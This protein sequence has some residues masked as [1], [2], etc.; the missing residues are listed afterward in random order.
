[1]LVALGWLA[2]AWTGGDD[3]PKTPT[4]PI[5][6]LVDVL[7]EK[8]AAKPCT[9]EK[10]RAND[11]A[12]ADAP[13]TA[14]TPTGPT[15]SS[16][17]WPLTLAEVMRIGLGNNE[18]FRNAQTPLA[19]RKAGVSS[20]RL[21]AEVMALVRSIEQCYWTLSQ[22]YVELWASEKAVE[23]AREVLK[24]EQAE[25]DIGGRGNKSDVA[26]AEQRLEQ[27]NLDM[28][29]RTSDVIEAERRL[30]NVL[31]L[32]RSDGRRITPMTKPRSDQVEPCW[33]E[34][35]ATM[36]LRQPDL[37]EQSERVRQADWLAKSASRVLAASLPGAELDPELARQIEGRWSSEAAR[38]A[39]LLKQVKHQTTHS[40]ARFFLEVDANYKQFKTASRLCAAS[41]QRLEA[42]RAFYEEG[43]IPIDRYLDAISQYASAKTQEA[44]FQATYNI[45]LVAL[46]EAK[47][48]LLNARDIEICEESSS[49]HDQTRDAAVETTAFTAAAPSDKTGDCC[50]RANTAAAP[51]DKAGDCCTRCKPEASPTANEPKAAPAPAAAAGKTL[52]IDLTI[53]GPQPITIR[54]TV[55]IDPAPVPAR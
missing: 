1:M 17:H 51:S 43:R 2:L 40:L 45:S 13:A 27:F 4:G 11:K 42:Q 15:E 26:E 12:K 19:Q 16:Q 32:P 44:Q 41:A 55:A 23:I 31:G 34:S 8:C 47:G 29:A 25:L 38:Q 50:T 53:G 5:P 54:G 37:A 46:E 10:C 7:K 39:E 52:R 9:G 24:R 20:W 14:T 30:R 28:V 36:L 49:A 33:D 21:K 22:K 18:A 35:L 48:T 3:A 6:V